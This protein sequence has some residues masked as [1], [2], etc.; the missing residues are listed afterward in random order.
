MAM[1][2]SWADED[3][4]HQVAEP[5]RSD[6]EFWSSL[7]ASADAVISLVAAVA[8]AVALR[9]VVA[10]P[11]ALVPFLVPAGFIVRAA[12]ASSSRH[13][14]EAFADQDAWRDAERAAVAASFMH[15][16]RR[17]RTGLRDER[18]A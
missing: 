12:M 14:R 4:A 11:W 9:L 8:V 1:I 3:W 2:P 7:A 15:V 6:H 10:G 18:R 17:P 5:F 16:V 13:R